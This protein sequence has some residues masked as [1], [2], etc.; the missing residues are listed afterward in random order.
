[1]WQPAVEAMRD[2]GRLEGREEHAERVA[3][4]VDALVALLDHEKGRVRAFV[5]AALIDLTGKA[6]LP[7]D[8]AAWAG[9]WAVKRAG[10]RPAPIARRPPLPDPWA[11]EAPRRRRRDE[12]DGPAADAPG[13]GASAAMTTIRFHG[14]PITSDRLALVID[15][16]GSMKNPMPVTRTSAGDKAMQPKIDVSKEELER[17][18]G[19]L[20]RDIEFNLIFFGTDVRAWQ[21]GLV[22]ASEPAKG[23]ALDF[24]RK[25]DIMGRTNFWGALSRAIGDPKT[26]TVYFLTDGGETTEGAYI[27]QRRITRHVLETARWSLVEIDCLLFGSAA[28]ARAGSASRRWLEG[29]AAATGGRFYIKPD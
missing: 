22:A 25:A 13:A 16:S 19:A 23:Q 29:L 4:A 5:I 27:D 11:R 8:H 6:D 7:D 15:L 14:I 26:D 18:I 2:L 1:P 17:T 3:A 10:F 9:W 12:G 21:P 28:Q 20:T 24:V